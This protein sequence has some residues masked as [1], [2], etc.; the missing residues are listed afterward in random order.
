MDFPSLGSSREFVR[1]SH[2]RALTM[3]T[4]LSRPANTCHYF[5]FCCQL[6]YSYTTNLYHLY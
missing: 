4:P 5:S 6:S 2:G 1:A 3:T